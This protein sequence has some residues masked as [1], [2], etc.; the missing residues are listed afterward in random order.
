LIAAGLML[1]L[2]LAWLLRPLL[3]TAGGGAG[4]DADASNVAIYRAQLAELDADLANGAIDQARYED[5]KRALLQRLALDVRGAQISEAAAQRSM[6]RAIAIFLAMAIPLVA[7]G[8]Y[9]RLGNT[10]ALALSAK[11]AA[12][13]REAGQMSPERVEAMV[14]KLEDYLKNNPN[15]GKGWALM[16][17]TYRAMG[18][19]TDAQT[20]FERAVA[21]A[22]QDAQLKTDLAEVLGML[23]QGDL[24]GRPAE[25]VEAALKLDANNAATL[26]LAG[27]VAAQRGDNAAA[28]K[29]WEKLLTLLPPE[30]AEL[31]ASLQQRI[32]E[33]RFEGAQAAPTKP[34]AAAA[35]VTLSV[36]L[37]PA[38]TG[39][40]DAQDTLFVFARAAQG[41]KMPLAVVK[42]K[43]SELPR[44]YTLSDANAMSPE[45]ALSKFEQIVVGARVSKAGSPIARSGDL[46]GVSD[47]VSAKG[48]KVKIVIDRVVP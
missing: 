38:L 5:G 46:E 19:L 22:P 1:L 10:E 21:L 18:K 27:S 41:P 11:D 12:L 32:N 17:R 40:V 39:K 7:G 43:P 24:R 45:L 2:A 48:A 28:I 23:A 6:P 3:R 34:G 15:D 47:V 16:A 20:A 29:H 8:L 37:D 44:E 42:A 14:H 25:L 31:R 13:Q 36:S 26:A 33:I 9:W 35:S 30:D 4:N